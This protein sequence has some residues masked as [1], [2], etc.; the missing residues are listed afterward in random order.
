MADPPLSGN[1]LGG[2]PSRLTIRVVFATGRVADFHDTAAWDASLVGA[3]DVSG[4]GKAKI[5][6]FNDTGASH[7]MGHILQWDGTQLVAV[8]G[9]NGHAYTTFIDGYALGGGGIR[10]V[11]NSFRATSISESVPT[12]W[13]ASET[14]FAWHGDQLVKVAEHR[15]IPIAD[16]IG[17]SGPSGLVGNNY[18]VPPEYSRIIGVHCAGLTNGTH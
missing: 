16:P 2:T 1:A 4:D 6:Y 8:K 3:A 15:P 12:G 5:F 7:H 14:I 10:C 9:P 18:Y 17:P 11:G 13:S